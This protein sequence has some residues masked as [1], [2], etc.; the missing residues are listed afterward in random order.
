[1]NQN[2]IT[3]YRPDYAW[4]AK[5]CGRLRKEVMEARLKGVHGVEA[6]ILVKVQVRALGY[7]EL[8]DAVDAISGATK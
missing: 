1:M 5:E 2:L 4:L 3:L 7:K 8:M 6:R